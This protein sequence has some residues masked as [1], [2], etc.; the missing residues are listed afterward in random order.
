LREW[1]QQFQKLESVDLRYDRQI[2][3]NPDLRGAE[4]QPRLSAA[5]AHAAMSAGVKPAALVNRERVKSAPVTL[6]KPA[7]TKSAKK[8]TT[9]KPVASKSAPKTHWHKPAPPVKHA[10]AKSA[11]A[12]HAAAPSTAKSPATLQK[13]S[14][15]VAKGQGTE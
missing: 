8:P 10:A 6:P 7:G 11:P 1:R 4:P 2:I 9:S 14:P 15:V 13:P 12:S 5:A 3:V